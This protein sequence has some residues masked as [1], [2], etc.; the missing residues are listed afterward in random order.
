MERRTFLLGLFGGLAAAVAGA[1]VAEA[2]PATTATTVPDLPDTAK[3]VEIASDDRAALEAAD[4]EFSQVYIVRRR[5]YR[6]RRVVYYRPRRVYYRR[7]VRVYYR[8]PV[9]VRRVIYRVY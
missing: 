8:R 4:K 6:P 9:R 3:A 7:P 5:Y 2:A 1:K